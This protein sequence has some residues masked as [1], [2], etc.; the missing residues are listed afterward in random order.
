[1]IF[2]DNYYF[3]SNMYG[4]YPNQDSKILMSQ[5]DLLT[6]TDSHL[7]ELLSSSA[8][9]DGFTFTTAE[10]AFQ[11]LKCKRP[12]DF[13]KILD[14]KNG[15]DAK[16]AAKGIPLRDNWS[17]HRDEVMEFIIHEKFQQHPDLRE[18]LVSIEETIHNDITWIDYYWGRNIQ[19]KQGRDML[20]VILKNERAKYIKEEIKEVN[21]K[22]KE[23]FKPKNL[24]KPTVEAFKEAIKDN[25]FYVLDTE[26]TGFSSIKND[27][28]ELSVIKVDGNTMQIVD[29]FDKFINIGKRLPVD[30]IK[31]NL[32]NGTGINDELLAN[33]PSPKFVADSFNYF[34]G[35]NPIIMGQNISFDIPFVNEF[36]KKNLNKPFEPSLVIDTLTM[37]KEKVEGKRNLSV[38]YEKIPDAPEMTFHK[39][40]DDVKATL[41]VAKWLIPMYDNEEIETPKLFE[42][43]KGIICQQVN[44][45]GKI[46]AGLA[47]AIIKEFPIVK[48]KFIENYE[49]NKNSQ[50]GSIDLIPLVDDKSLCVANIYSQ[51]YYGNPA[52]TG[53]VYTVAEVLVNAI[54]TVAS[55]NSDK[56]I[57]VPKNIGCGLGGEDW[58]NVKSLILDSV[59]SN[60]LK[61]VCFLNTLTCEKE[62]INLDNLELTNDF[63]LDER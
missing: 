14:C 11:A 32:K 31:F 10:Q 7:H 56:T 16:K 6:L 45:Q 24:Y 30:I 62:S 9:K 54:I 52:K 1:M 33:S 46:G 61:N 63:C 21:D 12:D 34:V 42:I 50:F 51:D 8:F 37:A 58:S 53:K 47:G 38:L 22:K 26:T 29:E 19:T 49:K 48:E 4:S 44:C 35:E 43:E 39:S 2:K 40:I 27:I 59:K 55:F 60:N 23:N 15:Y 20:G 41:E 5:T 13:L 36:Y 18:K 57:Y 25:Y 3:L 17:L 28:I